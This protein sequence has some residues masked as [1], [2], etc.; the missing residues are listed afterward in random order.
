MVVP[1]TGA[2]IFVQLYCT[3]RRFDV[4]ALIMVTVPFALVGG[5]WYVY[6]LGHHFSVASAVGFIALAGLAAEFGVIMLIYLKQAY[7]RRLESGAPENGKTLLE[8]INEG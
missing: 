8:A 3:Y 6:L 2:I 1:L 4:A 5:F 7:E